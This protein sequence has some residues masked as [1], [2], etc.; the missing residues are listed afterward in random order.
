[1]SAPSD[2]ALPPLRGRALLDWALQPLL[3]GDDAAAAA[4]HD[5]LRWNR[6][7]R[8]LRDG[9]AGAGLPAAAWKAV[10]AACDAPAAAGDTLPSSVR[11]ALV[12][13]RQR[14]ASCLNT[15]LEPP[16]AV[17]AAA[18]QA[19]HRATSR[20]AT[21]AWRA[22]ASEVLVTLQHAAQAAPNARKVRLRRACCGVECCLKRPPA[23]VRVAGGNCASG[24]RCGISRVA[25]RR[26]WRGRRAA[27]DVGVDASR[28]ALPR[29]PGQ[30]PRAG[31]HF[32]GSISGAQHHARCRAASPEASQANGAASRQRCG[33]TAQLAAGGFV[34]PRLLPR[35]IRHALRLHF[36]GST[37]DLTCSLRRRPML[38]FVAALADA[39]LWYDGTTARHRSRGLGTRCCEQG[40]R[41]C[42]SAALWLCPLCLDARRQQARRL[43][44]LDNS[45]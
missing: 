32:R 10:A 43:G 37:R 34:P 18:A 39:L 33:C 2:D 7:A 1:M 12:Q 11:E 15:R 27:A 23:D 42:V 21:A 3:G 24:V 17:A 19:L 25:V 5:A 6:L 41:V 14:R 45:G 9:L 35:A 16:E 36:D 31:C 4:A 29:Q 40:P 28:C 13:A 38:C 30:R 26:W 44:S 8:V 22:L 20:D